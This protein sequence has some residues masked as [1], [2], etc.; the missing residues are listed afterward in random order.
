MST[1]GGGG[2]RSDSRVPLVVRE[3]TVAR[4]RFAT[5]AVTMTTRHSTAFRSYVTR[6]V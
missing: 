4:S 3:R 5:G 2:G 1:G 6:D